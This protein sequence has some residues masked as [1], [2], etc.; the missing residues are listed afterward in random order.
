MLF[1][2]NAK[3]SCIDGSCGR[4]CGAASPILLGARRAAPPAAAMVTVVRSAQIRSTH[5]VNQVS[6][7]EHG[8]VVGVSFSI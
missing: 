5:G 8:L 6:N 7:V 4:R 2:I 3:R 1:N